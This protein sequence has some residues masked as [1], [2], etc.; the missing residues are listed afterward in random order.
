MTALFYDRVPALWS[1]VAY[2]S[3]AGLG[4]WFADLLR[5]LVELTSWTSDFATP[6][7]VWLAGLFNPQSFLTAVMQ[8]MEGYTRFMSATHLCV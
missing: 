6:A 5:R 8:G 1:A 7:C 2:P 3:Q 4:A